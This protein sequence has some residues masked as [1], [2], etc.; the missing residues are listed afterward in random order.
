MGIHSPG[1]IEPRFA[2]P[3]TGFARL[4]P[5]WWLLFLSGGLALAAIAGIVADEKV[6]LPLLNVMGLATSIA[7]LAGVRMHHPARRMP[8]QL[9]ALC[10]ALTTIGMGMVPKTGDLAIVGT[11]LTGAGFVTG[12]LGFVML[13]RG[14]IPGG[15]R[16]A[17]LDAAILA[18]G[19]GVL[20]W[21]FG[22]APYLLAAGQ[23]NSVAAAAFFYPALIA[24]AT[25][26]PL[27]FLSGAHRPATRLLVLLVLATLAL[28]FIDM[29]RGL[30]GHGALAGPYL[31]AEFASLAFVSAAALHPSMAFAAERHSQELRPIGR[32]RIVAL[33]AALL[34]NPATLAIELLGQRQ[35]DP[36]PYLIGG[37]LI[38]ILVIARLGGA[39]RQ[40]SDSLRERESLMELLRRQALYDALTTLPN[41]SL[42]TERLTADFAKRSSDRV[43]AVLLVDLDDFKAVN[44]SY[45][46]VAGDAL[47]VSVGER[48]RSSIREG[49]TAARFGG[50]EFVI[51][52][53]TCAD[54][55]VA[56][57]VAQR[58]LATLSEPFDIGGHQLTVHASVGVAVAGPDERTADD[59]VRNADIAMYLAKS[60]GKG[61]FEVFDPSMQAAATSQLEL[62]TDLAAASRS[63][64]RGRRWNGSAYSAFAWPST[65]SGSAIRL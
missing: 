25:A 54:A 22:F 24:S 14:R 5:P 19:T 64:W 28:T 17:F 39:L 48:L 61:R 63:R 47:L 62:R 8:W 34:V 20:I 41:R 21:A 65:T 46:H 1:L 6:L 10:T 32:R 12:F 13:M 60:R 2:A 35:V 11:A 7:I 59:L 51:S 23:Q 4:R 3:R 42:F 45:G 9:I 58:V 40:L 55:T 56:V 18:S 44:D 26:A 49:D 15:E 27:W 33:A 43:L 16:A 31:F 36:A 57:R 50:D 38:G 30:I 52:L 53:P 29:L 37:A